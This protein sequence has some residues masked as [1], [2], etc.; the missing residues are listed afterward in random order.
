LTSVDNHVLT[1]ADTMS[2]YGA[3]RTCRHGSLPAAIWGNWNAT[4]AVAGTA[5]GLATLPFAGPY[6]YGKQKSLYLPDLG[7]LA[8]ITLTANDC[9]VSA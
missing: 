5:L 1:R 4:A 3:E 2:P 6:Y 7:A 9:T 8:V